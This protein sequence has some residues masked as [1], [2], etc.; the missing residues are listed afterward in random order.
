MGIKKETFTF[1]NKVNREMEKLTKAQN[2]T[3]EDPNKI[4]H[5]HNSYYIKNV[6]KDSHRKNVQFA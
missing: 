5:E 6:S 1:V 4:S 3:N 2:Y